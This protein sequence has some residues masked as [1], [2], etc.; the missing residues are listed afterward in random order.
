MPISLP[1]YEEIEAQAL[2]FARG[3]LPGKDTHTE[4]WLGK[5]ARAMARL[6]NGFHFSVQSADYDAVPSQNT[7][8]AGL[9]RLAERM[10]LSNGAGGYGR[11]LATAATG[12]AGLCEGT[13]GITFP[14][15]TQLL[16]PDGVTIIELSG[17][18]DVPGIPPGTDS[19]SGSFFA[20]TKGTGGNLAIGTVLTWINPPVGATET[21]TL[22]AALAG[23]EDLETDEALLARILDRWQIPAEGGT[24]SEYRAWAESIEGVFRAYEYNGRDGLGT[25]S[26]VITSAGTG[27]ARIPSGSVQSDVTDYIDGSDIEEG[28][29]PATVAGYSTLLPD[30]PAA[31]GLTLR[32]RVVPSL[33]KYAFDW[34]LGTTTFTVASYTTGVITTTEALPTSLMAAVDAGE[35]PRIQVLITNGPVV[36]VMVRVTGYNSGAKTL[37]LDLPDGWDAVAPVATNPIYPGG[38]VVEQTASDLLDYVDGLGPSRLSG[39]A[40]PLDL[41]ED[42]VAVFRMAQVALDA[43]DTDNT[44]L[45]KNITAAT[46]NGV[47][48]DRQAQ[49]S[50]SDGPEL[51]YAK[52]VAVTD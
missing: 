45:N 29:R 47:A 8:S 25:V 23:A 37:T 34:S 42:T 46:V 6:V 52:F 33:A 3:R 19:A 50:T 51:L 43:R 15:G 30:M 39:F 31:N 9:D 35:E 27:T 2:A 44:K 38:P 4:S 48:T 26:T 13:K 24:P 21:V 20:V 5:I 32:V 36:P 7:S 41:W 17:D 49:D 18:V 11:S 22:T 10:G 28:Q 14:D 1:T 16:A 12:G 40:N